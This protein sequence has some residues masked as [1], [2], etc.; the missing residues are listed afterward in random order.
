MAYKAES[1]PINFSL[2]K[3]PLRMGAK[4][5]IDEIKAARNLA[6]E[7][8]NAYN[9]DLN[10]SQKLTTDLAARL[11]A[12]GMDVN[13]LLRNSSNIKAEE[14]N[15]RQKM[16]QMKNRSTNANNEIARIN[17]EMENLTN[18]LKNQ[19]LND[20]QRR[21]INETIEKLKASQAEQIKLKA[22]SEQSLRELD[23]KMKSN[24]DIYKY[25]NK[26]DEQ[27]ELRKRISTVQK[28][29][30]DLNNE[31]RQRERF[32]DYDP[33][34]QEDIRTLVNDTHSRVD[35]DTGNIITGAENY[36]TRIDDKI[37][38]KE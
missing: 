26:I 29:I 30:D 13:E 10:T 12:K 34:P 18:E 1:A 6:T 22:N 20:E 4:A 2:A 15:L 8:L 33:S 14:S 11:S 23:D 17:K 38:P 5:R 19:N 31:K 27:N 9:T 32:Y 24:E 28:D 7:Q 3:A 36:R 25:I 21:G 35:Q 16:E 37:K